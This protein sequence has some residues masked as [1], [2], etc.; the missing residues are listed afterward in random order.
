MLINPNFYSS[1][2]FFDKSEKFRSM[3]ASIKRINKNIVFFSY[4]TPVIV[5]LGNKWYEDETFYSMTTCKQKGK[6]KRDM[7]IKTRVLH[8]RV[9]R[10]KLEKVLYPNLN[11]SFDKKVMGV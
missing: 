10:E 2:L 4:D 11:K 1:N 7:N 3:N 9:F 6:F 5:R 8:P